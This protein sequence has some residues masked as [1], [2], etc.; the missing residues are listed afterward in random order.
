MTQPID[1]IPVE[2]PNDATQR[3]RGD[4]LLQELWAAKAALNAA[5]DYRVEQLA[6]QATQFDIDVLLA[7]LNEK[8][9]H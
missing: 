7:Q 8:S 1:G 2:Q 4:T 9:R 3:G 6:E 5:A